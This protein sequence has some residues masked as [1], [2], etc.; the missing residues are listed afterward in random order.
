M[1][2]SRSDAGCQPRATSLHG[3]HT[4]DGH[5]RLR[6]S[7]IRSLARRFSWLVS[8]LV[9]VGVCLV[10]RWYA[11]AGPAAA[12]SKPPAASGKVKQATA[13][14]PAEPGGKNGPVAPKKPQVAAVVNNEPIS[15]EDLARECLLHYGNE[16]LETMVN[17]LLIMAA[18]QE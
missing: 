9:I 16:V 17:K 3:G 6:T 2:R 12:A 1:A 5:L 14:V 7:R 11:P 8:G 4:M 13:T 10:Y 15:R 18:C